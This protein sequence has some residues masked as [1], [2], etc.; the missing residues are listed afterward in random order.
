[1]KKICPTSLAVSMKD[2]VDRNIQCVE[3]KLTAGISKDDLNVF[4]QVAQKKT[5]NMV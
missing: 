3:D 4:F 5:E 2:E 1:M